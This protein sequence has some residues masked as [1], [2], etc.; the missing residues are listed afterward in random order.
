MLNIY[1]DK[2]Y[3]NEEFRSLIFPLLFD[4]WFVKNKKIESYYKLV[5]NIFDA[6]IVIVPVDISYY[7]KS[8]NTAR[9]F[10]F[11]EKASHLQKKVWVYSAGD[12]GISLKKNVYTFRLGGF[13]SKLNEQTF[14]LPG[15]TTDPYECLQ[16]EFEPLEKTMQPQIGFVGNADGSLIKYLKEFFFY[17]KLNIGRL[18]RKKYCDY[19]SFYPSSIKR[20]KYLKKIE[21]SNFIET[22]FIYRKKYRAGARTEDE[23]K[24]TTFEF[25]KNIQLNSYTFCLRGSGN[26]SI[27]FYETLAMG[28]IPVIIDTDIRLP[29]QHIIDWSKH[30]IL[31]NKYNFE[32]KLLEFHKD[33]NEVEFKKKQQNN[34]ELWKN[35][36]II[37]NYFIQIYLIFKNEI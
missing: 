28:R 19:Q 37:E 24:K 5:T 22:N 25:Y 4:L 23:I 18:A 21:A 7:Y 9:L 29:L 8:N 35:Y 2:K 34:R 6:D 12:F 20:F 10:N 17:L 32:T 27:R 16:E 15:H 36:L 13:H 26:F 1:T 33:I 30:C 11:I 3:L 31:V 14:V